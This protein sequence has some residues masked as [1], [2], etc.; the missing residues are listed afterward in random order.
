MRALIKIC[1]QVVCIPFSCDCP[2]SWL[3]HGTHKELA[4]TDFPRFM[5][6]MKIV[7]RIVLHLNLLLRP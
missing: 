4:Q 6:P 7:M 3:E 1:C 5:K 2:Y